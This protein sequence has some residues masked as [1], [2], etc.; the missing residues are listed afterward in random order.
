VP[1]QNNFLTVRTDAAGDTLWTCFIGGIDNDIANVVREAVD[2][3][4]VVAGYTRSYGPG[5][6]SANV[7]V[8]RY[9]GP[10]V[11]QAVVARLVGDQLILNWANDGN[12]YYRLSSDVS[13]NGPFITFEGSTSDTT[14]TIND[15]TSLRK[16]YQVVGSAAP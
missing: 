16:F 10:T 5:T 14:F 1:A 13:S 9:R 3:G 7:Y 2:G 12:L 8:V 11:P 15:V 6:P 4:Y